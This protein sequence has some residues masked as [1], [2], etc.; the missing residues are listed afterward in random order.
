MV[1]K[2]RIMFRCI[3]SSLVS[4]RS[5]RSVHLLKPLVDLLEAFPHLDPEFAQ[6]AVD[7]PEGLVQLLVGP[8]LPWHHDHAGN[9]RKLVV[10]SD[11]QT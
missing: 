5:K 6:I 10:N 2:Q 7:P 1:T 4:S 9:H 3:A 11:A 8:S